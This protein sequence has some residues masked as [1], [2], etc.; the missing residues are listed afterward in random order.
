MSNFREFQT[1][2]DMFNHFHNLKTYD[3][4]CYGGKH[5]IA[6]KGNPIINLLDAGVKNFREDDS[7]DEIC[8]YKQ[9]HHKSEYK[10]NNYKYEYKPNYYSSSD[11]SDSDSSYDFSSDDAISSDDDEY[12]ERAERRNRKYEK[13]K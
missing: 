10:N 5:F 3:E 9:K 13:K 6:N 7:D 2:D 4:Y 11:T 12:Y 1:H 8:A